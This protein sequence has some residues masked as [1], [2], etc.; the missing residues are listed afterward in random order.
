MSNLAK[1]LAVAS[2]VCTLAAA[3]CGSG[4][5]SGT[6]PSGG[7][8]AAAA[9]ALSAEARSAAT[10]DIPDNQVFLVF[11]NAAERYS[12][13]YPEG[14]TL[15][16]SGKDVT[17]RSKN[18][19]VHITTGS[20]APP[21]PAQVE[22][23]LQALRSS[24]PSLTFTPPRTLTLAGKRAIKATYTT[25]SVA[26]PVTGK[27]VVLIVDRYALSRAGQ[28]AIVDLGTPEGVD[29]VDAYRKMIESFQ[30]E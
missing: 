4:G 3:G 16:G 5:T 22:R 15:S 7:T 23:S 14:W 12:I 17:F 30:W 11:R 28:M 26:D 24:T 13:K 27:S 2:W 18:N 20:G 8:T 10:G 19:I 21:T 9:G 6:S 1:T 25:R 29:N